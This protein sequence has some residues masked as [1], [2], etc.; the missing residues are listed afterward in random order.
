MPTS[1]YGYVYRCIVDGANSY[2]SKLTFSTTWIGASTEYF[3]P[4]ETGNFWSCG[5]APDANTDV[6]INSGAVI[7]SSNAVCRSLKLN[8]NAASLQLTSGYKLSITK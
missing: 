7:I 8:S 3:Y 5:K 6:I 4:W 1:A 2:L